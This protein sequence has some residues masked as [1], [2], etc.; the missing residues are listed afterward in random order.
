MHCSVIAGHRTRQSDISE[1]AV[2][3]HGSEPS[4][5]ENCLTEHRER[6]LLGLAEKVANRPSTFSRRFAS[7]TPP[8]LNVESSKVSFC[9]AGAFAVS[10]FPQHFEFHSSRER[11]DVVHNHPAAASTASAFVRARSHS[12][13]PTSRCAVGLG[14]TIDSTIVALA[15][16]VSVELQFA[17][18]CCTSDSGWQCL[19]SSAFAFVRALVTSDA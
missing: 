17:S 18:P 19:G 15:G 13:A 8:L 7:P 14:H 9:S 11:S 2:G 1:P 5:P 3:A 6:S 12:A 10:S 16:F 4:N